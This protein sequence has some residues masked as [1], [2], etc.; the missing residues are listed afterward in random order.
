VFVRVFNCNAR[1]QYRFEL[2]DPVD[3]FE[4]LEQNDDIGKVKLLCSVEKTSAAEVNEE[5]SEPLASGWEAKVTPEGRILYVNNEKQQTQW[6]HP[7]L[8]DVELPE[9]WEKSVDDQGRAYY[10]NTKS[11]KTG[12]GS[13][14]AK[15]T[16][17]GSSMHTSEREKAP[18]TKS[19]SFLGSWFAGKNKTKINNIQAGSKS[20]GNNIDVSLEEAPQR[21]HAQF[22]FYFLVNLLFE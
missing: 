18:A 7:G 6:S 9:G 17:A 2:E 15:E 3:D 13:V 22:F 14:T 16:R 21:A 10:I 4:P 8:D 5:D 1:A 12:Q 19:L 11:G 20:I